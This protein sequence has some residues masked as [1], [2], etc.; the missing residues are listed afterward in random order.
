[1]GRDSTTAGAKT[2]QQVSSSSSAPDADNKVLQLSPYLLRA[3][4]SKEWLGLIRV[5]Q[6]S[7]EASILLVLGSRVAWRNCLH[8]NPDA[9]TIASAIF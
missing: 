6:K 1:M 8:V 7:S 4:K 5:V 2:K 3:D 9:H